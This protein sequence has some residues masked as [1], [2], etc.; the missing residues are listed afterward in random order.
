MQVQIRAHGLF[1]TCVFKGLSTAQ[2]N[3]QASLGTSNRNGLRLMSKKRLAE[4]PQGNEESG[5]RQTETWQLWGPV[6]R[7]LLQWKNAMVFSVLLFL[8]MI[9]SLGRGS[10][11]H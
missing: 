8:L 2:G 5:S 10:V 11:L 1:C 3:S 9:Q 6:W 4:K 7:E